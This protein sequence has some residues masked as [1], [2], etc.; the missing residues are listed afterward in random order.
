VSVRPSLDG[1]PETALWTL[2]FRCVAA[3]DED[4]LLDDP[5]AIEACSCT[6]SRSWCTRSSRGAEVDFA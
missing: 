2:W 6:C 5:V 1:V 3:R 4:G